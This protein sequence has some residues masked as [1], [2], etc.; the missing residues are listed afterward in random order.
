MK[1]SI[2][3]SKILICNRLIDYSNELV[4]FT[5]ICDKFVDSS[6][7]KIVLKEKRDFQNIDLKRFPL[8]R[9]ITVADTNILADV[10][11]LKIN[12]FVGGRMK[13]SIFN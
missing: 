13:N 2:V 5:S 12:I 7:N 11:I 8:H 9:R 1:C 3:V 6:L 4:I 10:Q